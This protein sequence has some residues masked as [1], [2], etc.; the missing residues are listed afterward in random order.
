MESKSFKIQKLIDQIPEGV[1]FTFQQLNCPDIAPQLLTLV[2]S[3]LVKRGLLQRPSKGRY[4]KALKTRFGSLPPSDNQMIESIL[5]SNGK[6][7]I[8]YI[9]GIAA[10]N[11]L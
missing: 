7:S 11:Q 1:I 3:R 4:M 10:Y 9:S 6:R 5:S 8:S 2:L